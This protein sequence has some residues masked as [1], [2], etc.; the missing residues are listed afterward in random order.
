MESVFQLTKFQHYKAVIRPGALYEAETLKLCHKGL[1]ENLEKK[2]RQII[3][4][5]IDRNFQ[6]KT[7]KINFK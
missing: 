4:N 6:K 7:D 3:R 2:D 5:I 1:L